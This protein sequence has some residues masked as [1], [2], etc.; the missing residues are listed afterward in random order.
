MDVGGITWESDLRYLLRV[1][2]ELLDRI[3]TVWVELPNTKVSSCPTGYWTPFKR[4]YSMTEN[5]FPIWNVYQIGIR[6]DCAGQVDS[7]INSDSVSL[8]NN[9]FTFRRSLSRKALRIQFNHRLQAMQ[10]MCLFSRSQG[11]SLKRYALCILQISRTIEKQS[12]RL[13]LDQTT[14]FGEDRTRV[15]NMQYWCK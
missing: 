2:F 8:P 1:F 10:G 6:L 7:L 11:I 14:N 4:L 3:S 5:S 15:K 13:E 9:Q 12:N